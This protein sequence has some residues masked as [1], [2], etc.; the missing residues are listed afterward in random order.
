MLCVCL[1]SSEALFDG[2]CGGL[3]MVAFSEPHSGAASLLFGLSAPP[4]VQR[5]LQ[6]R[7]ASLL[8]VLEVLSL[9]LMA[10]A[11][12]LGARLLLIGGEPSLFSVCPLASAFGVLA[13]VVYRQ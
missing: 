9:A 6:V 2:R 1:K 13:S 11:P 12:V 5:N 3:G 8:E 7:V 10:A 4:P